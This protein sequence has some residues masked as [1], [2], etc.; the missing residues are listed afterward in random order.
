MVFDL[1][2]ISEVLKGSAL[3][4]PVIVIICYVMFLKLSTIES[5]EVIF[6]NY[7]FTNSANYFHR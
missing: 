3:G 1:P 5:K 2:V 4:T 6:Q 7:Y